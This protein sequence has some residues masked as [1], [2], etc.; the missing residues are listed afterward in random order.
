LENISALPFTEVTDFV[1]CKRSANIYTVEAGRWS[2][3]SNTLGK[4]TY[5]TLPG[6]ILI[7]T[8]A[9]PETVPD[10]KRFGRRWAFAS[11][12]MIGKDE[13]E[14]EAMSSTNFKVEALLDHEVNNPWKPMYAIFLINIISNR[15]I[16]KVLHKFQNLNIVKEVLCT[17]LVVRSF[18]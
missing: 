1:Q 13:E 10:L 9:K 2:N 6:D 7:L 5:R 11:V 14:N 8:D 15:R 17:D 4:E 12:M 3:E 16:W 18:S